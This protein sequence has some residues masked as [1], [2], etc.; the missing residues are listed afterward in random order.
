MFSPIPAADLYAVRAESLILYHTQRKAY[1]P[2]RRVVP[3]K[4]S[5]I[6]F[7]VVLLLF[8]TPPH[9]TTPPQRERRET[10]K[11]RS[12]DRTNTSY[13]FNL[14]SWRACKA[15]EQ[16]SKREAARKRKRTN[17]QAL[18]PERE[19]EARASDTAPDTPARTKEPRTE[20]TTPH[21]PAPGERGAGAIEK[22]IFFVKSKQLFA[23]AFS[24]NR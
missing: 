17:T 10:T 19:S 18:Q 15:G 4:K 13:I 3:H 11:G 8:Y 1:Y 23:G 22:N 12:K 21:H 20:R 2:G 24:F 9:D 16:H 14:R 7:V 6:G 5:I